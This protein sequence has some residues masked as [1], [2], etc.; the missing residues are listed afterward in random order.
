M[1]ATIFKNAQTILRRGDGVYSRFP[2]LLVPTF[3]SYFVHE[4]NMRYYEGCDLFE[5]YYDHEEAERLL[6]DLLKIRLTILK[7]ILLFLKE[8]YEYTDEGTSASPFGEFDR[9][10]SLKIL[11]MQIR[12]I[13]RKEDLPFFWGGRWDAKKLQIMQAESK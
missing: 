2:F 11:S 3:H 1:S 5:N 7:S 4:N 8:I 13:E 6:K 12:R 10:I 9:R